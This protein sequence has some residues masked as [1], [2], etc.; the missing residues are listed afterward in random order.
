[1]S[2]F[3]PHQRCCLNLPSYFPFISTISLIFYFFSLSARP[4]ITQPHFIVLIQ[5]SPL[6]LYFPPPPSLSY[7]SVLFFFIIPGS[8][9]SLALPILLTSLILCLFVLFFAILV[10]LSLPAL[11]VSFLH[12]RLVLLSFLLPFLLFCY[13]S[14]PLPLTFL[15]AFSSTASVGYSC[16]PSYCSHVPLSPP[17]C[18]LFQCFSSSLLTPACPFLHHAFTTFVFSRTFRVLFGVPHP[19]QANSKTQLL[20]DFRNTVS[21]SVSPGDSV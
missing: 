14:M 18:P 20:A 16:M 13:C 17:P 2:L 9:L 6:F 7:S 11:Y 3:F 15:Y 19:I 8:P 5:F 4:P 21:C 10:F 1:M 12:S